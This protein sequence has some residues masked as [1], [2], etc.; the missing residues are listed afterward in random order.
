[1]NEG[2][3]QGSSFEQA[4]EG[5][6]NEGA[7]PEQNLEGQPGTTGDKSSIY[8]LDTADKVKWQGKEW[9]R[10]ELKQQFMMQSDYSKKTEALKEERRYADNFA[11]DVLAVLK[12]PNLANRFKQIYPQEYHS[13]VDSAV[14]EY[15]KLRAQGMGHDQASEMSQESQKQEGGFPPEFMTRFE[16]LEAQIQQTNVA[17]T[18]AQLDATI[19]KLSQKYPLPKEGN[20]YVEDAVMAKANVLLDE[21]HKM[22][23]EIWDKLWKQAYDQIKTVS[24]HIYSQQVKTQKEA[25][26]KGRDVGSGGGI[27]ASAPKMPRTIQEATEMLYKE[28]GLG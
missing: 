20:K 18:E 7:A 16:R 12:N 5:F 13:H 11:Y 4:S 10:D 21:G 17:K 8:D 15:K 3:E 1:M 27:P 28:Q 25:N 22:T 6:A 23:D 14:S 26:T 2:I 19:E 24:S 9:T